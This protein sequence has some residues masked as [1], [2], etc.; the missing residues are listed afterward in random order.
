QFGRRKEKLD[1]DMRVGDGLHAGRDFTS[2]DSRDG[3]Q[4]SD[5]FAG[6]RGYL[7]GEFLLFAGGAQLEPLRSRFGA[8][9]RREFDPQ[10]AGSIGRGGPHGDVDGIG[11]GRGEKRA[12]DGHVYSR[13][14]HNRKCAQTFAQ[15]AIG[16]AVMDGTSDF[17]GSSVYLQFELRLKHGG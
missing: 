3:M 12:A 5:R 15:C 8:P 14:G 11:S 10:L 1:G 4:G 9:A 2:T 17:D 13:S 16:V 6:W 7:K